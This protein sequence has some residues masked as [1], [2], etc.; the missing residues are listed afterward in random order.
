M[1][2]EQLATSALVERISFC[3]GLVA[4]INTGDTKPLWD[5]EI[6]IYSGSIKNNEQLIGTIPIQVKGTNKDIVPTAPTFDFRV[7]VSDLR[8]YKDAFGVMFFVVVIGS[9]RVRHIF[10]KGL[11]S[12]DLDRFINNA[13]SNKTKSIVFQ[14]FPDDDKTIR[15]FMLAFNA[16]RKRQATGVVW[17]IEQAMAAVSKGAPM[18]FHFQSKQATHNHHDIMR[19]ITASTGSF[20]YYVE[21]AEGIE[22]PFDKVENPSMLMVRHTIQ[23]PIFANGKQ[24]YDSFELGYENGEQYIYIGGFIRIPVAKEGVTPKKINFKHTINGT[25]AKRLLECEFV[26]ALSQNSNIYIGEKLAFGIS[27][28]SSDEVSLIQQMH[29]NLFRIRKMLD[30]F[31]VQTDLAMDKLTDA[32]FDEINRLYH[33]SE[34]ETLTFKEKDLPIWFFNNKKIGN[35]TIRL[36]AK[37]HEDSDAYKLYNAFA[38]N[39][40]VK[41]VTEAAGG[42]KETHEPW[43]LF[44]YMKAEDFLCSNVNYDAILNSIKAMNRRDIE[45]EFFASETQS[46]GTTTM[47]LEI[48]KAYDSQPVKDK[49]FLQFSIDIADILLCKNPITIINRLQSIKRQRLLTNDEIARLVELRNEHYDDRVVSCAVSI[50]LD[51]KDKA[52][53]MLDE[54]QEQERRSIT[55]YPIYSLLSK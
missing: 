1:D 17:T 28:S 52:R 40:H 42:T 2:T 44:I 25:L 35:I 16:D 19:E 32:D 55:D 27:L 46:I 14:R 50:L 12:F 5:G 15:Q 6:F 53:K 3:D 38:D 13:G 11:L 9:D 22:I 23:T 43:S 51:E 33:A 31:G 7:K 45:F 26:L 30:Y 18:R 49:V 37:K 20:Y 39:A 41:M 4:H 10:H 54:M 48:L 34:G 24:Y 21:V 8:K 29:E 36:L 47:F